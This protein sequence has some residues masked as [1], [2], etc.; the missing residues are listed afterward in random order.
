MEN[1]MNRKDYWLHLSERY[2]EAETTDREEDM[3]KAFLVSKEG[4]DCDFDEV[5]AVM[6]FV[7]VGRQA[8]RKAV[9]GSKHFLRRTAVIYAAAAAC[10]LLILTFVSVG[11]A[12]P[13][14]ECVAYISG[15]KITDVDK[16]LLEMQAAWHNVQSDDDTPTI[17]QQL[18]GMFS[19]LEQEE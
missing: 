15:E 12:E 14:E 2:F 5:R 9:S 3:L 16:I 7:A 4:Q 8:N 10:V 17:E 18:S 1:K 6:G 11:P 13:D 19:T